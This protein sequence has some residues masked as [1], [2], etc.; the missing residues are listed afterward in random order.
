MGSETRPGNQEGRVWLQTHPVPVDEP[1]HAS[2]CCS[3][4]AECQLPPP[5]TPTAYSPEAQLE[6]LKK[7]DQGDR[8]AGNGLTLASEESDGLHAVDIS[9]ACSRF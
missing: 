5:S 3:Q 4:L 8:L 7:I 6:R 1:F 2:L 9:S